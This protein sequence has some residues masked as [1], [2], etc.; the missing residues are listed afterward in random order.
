MLTVDTEDDSNGN[1]TII[2]FYDGKKHN[3]FT[4]LSLRIDAWNFLSKHKR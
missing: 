3:T 1:V 4:G 2:D